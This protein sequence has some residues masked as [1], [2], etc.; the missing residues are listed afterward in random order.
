MQYPALE[1]HYMC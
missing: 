1:R